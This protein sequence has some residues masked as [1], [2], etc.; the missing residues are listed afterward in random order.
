MSTGV[1]LSQSSS[2]HNTQLKVSL[3]TNTLFWLFQIKIQKTKFFVSLLGD[4][5]ALPITKITC[6]LGLE[7]NS[8]HAWLLGTFVLR[9]HK[10]YIVR[11]C[12]KT[13]LF[14]MQ[15]GTH[16]GIRGSQFL[17]FRYVGSQRQ[18]LLEQGKVRPHKDLCLWVVLEPQ[19]QHDQSPTHHFGVANNNF[20]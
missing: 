6:T 11:P 1:P 2:L 17:I 14:I 5:L 16:V 3:S 15:W 9:P 19:C 12:L 20:C 4:I 8:M 18:N 13:I 10:G 7:N